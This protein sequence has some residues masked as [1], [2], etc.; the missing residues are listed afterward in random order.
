MKSILE[1]LY[2]S[3]IGFDS[4]PYDK[5]SQYMEA[6]RRRQELKDKLVAELTEQERSLLSEYDDFSA[7]VTD[8]ARYDTFVH[9]LRFAILLMVEVFTGA[10]IKDGDSLAFIKELFNLER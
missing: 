5:D 2:H 6:V 1:T 9:S 8:I 10:E 4:R 3:A 7:D